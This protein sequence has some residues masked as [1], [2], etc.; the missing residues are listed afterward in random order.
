M[1]CT[2]VSAKVTRA[3]YSCSKA[4]YP[5]AHMLSR[6]PRPG[7]VQFQDSSEPVASMPTEEHVTPVSRAHVRKNL[8]IPHKLSAGQRSKMHKT[9]DAG[10]CVTS[11]ADGQPSQADPV[12]A[13]SQR[14]AADPDPPSARAQTPPM[15]MWPEEDRPAQPAWQTWPG[16]MPP[17]GAQPV[18]C[19]PWNAMYQPPGTVLVQHTPALP[20]VIP[21]QHMLAANHFDPNFLQPMLYYPPAGPP[22]TA[23]GVPFAEDGTGS[24]PAMSP[25]VSMGMAGAAGAAGGFVACPPPNPGVP[26]AVQAALVPMRA[27]PCSDAFVA[28]PSGGQVVGAQG[29]S[30]AVASSSLAGCAGVLVSE[31]QQRLSAPVQWVPLQP[32]FMAQTMP[33]DRGVS[34]SNQP[35]RCVQCGTGETA[36]WRCKGTMCNACGLRVQR[37]TPAKHAKELRVSALLNAGFSIERKPYTRD[38]DHPSVGISIY[39]PEGLRFQSI[40]S[41]YAY[42][43]ETCTAAPVAW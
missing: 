7:C 8:A 27:V 32:A 3:C 13:T 12:A 22:P 19:P 35:R 21:G 20:G 36:M 25:Y 17:H 29:P 28:N 6:Q 2:P 16:Q 39:S 4:L 40:K 30:T 33:S 11:P 10:S 14:L 31:P 15:E 5:C 1:L 34:E 41:A 18:P 37:H 9:T 43:T 38:G 26:S 24:Y 42:Y 23:M